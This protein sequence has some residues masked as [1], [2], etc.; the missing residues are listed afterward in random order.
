MRKCLMG[1]VFFLVIVGLSANLY[2]SQTVGN[3]TWQ[4]S[5]IKDM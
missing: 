2:A 1:L 3:V 5:Q 4:L